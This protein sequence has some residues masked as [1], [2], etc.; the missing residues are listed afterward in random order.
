VNAIKKMVQGLPVLLT[1][2][3]KNLGSGVN[4]KG[5][6]RRLK[7]SRYIILSQGLK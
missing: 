1:E 4:P 6:S 7:N 2:K 3:E 5:F